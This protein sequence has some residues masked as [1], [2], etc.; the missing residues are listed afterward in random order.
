MNIEGFDEREG[1]P[2]ALFLMFFNT[3][4]IRARAVF[5]LYFLFNAVS[6]PSPRA[7][8]CER[9][10]ERRAAVR[11]GGGERDTKKP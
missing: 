9:V 10:R 7:H 5:F 2:G 6:P 4:I 8:R 1:A 3:V 11:R